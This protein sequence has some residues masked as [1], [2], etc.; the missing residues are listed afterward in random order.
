MSLCAYPIYVSKAGGLVPCGQCLPCRINR[1]KKKTARLVLES[2]Q[3]EHVLF[4]TLT[5]DNDHLPTEYFDHETGEVLY[6]NPSGVLDPRSIELFLKRLRRRMPPKS[7]RF[8]ACGEY[9]EK[10]TRPHYHLLL[11]GLPYKS[12]H[13]LF[14]CWADPFTG[15]PFCDPDRLDVQVPSSEW[16]V[17]Q[18]VSS[19]VMKKLTKA[20][21]PR[22][23]GRTPEFFR[24]SKGIGIKS[25]DVLAD[26][27]SSFS[28]KCYIE[29]QGDIPRVLHF[30]GRKLPIDRYMREKILEALQIAPKLKELGSERFQK[31]MSDLLAR[32]ALNPQIP[33][34]WLGDPKREAWALEK[35]S[36]L[37]NAQ[38]VLNVERR[39]D[40]FNNGRKL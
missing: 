4:V 9:G 11:F 35:Q 38:A 2:R 7:L 40:L 10:N 28:A 27:L 39:Y 30:N 29:S 14:D 24:Q 18:Y 37:E 17:G 23:E 13:L 32:A 34:S 26:A 5:Y 25:V 31:D 8:F 22:L 21:D 3:H 12:K 19:Y 36:R 1:R 16:D 33:K 15:V 20:D 6:S